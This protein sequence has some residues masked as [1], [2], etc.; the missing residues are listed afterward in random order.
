MPEAVWKIMSLFLEDLQI[1]GFQK[2]QVKL[3][4]SLPQNSALA[5]LTAAGKIIM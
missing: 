4:V 3:R 1:G 5:K 2:K